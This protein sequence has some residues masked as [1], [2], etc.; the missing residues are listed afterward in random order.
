[1]TRHARPEEA[2]VTTTEDQEQSPARGAPH[3]D[4]QPLSNSQLADAL[5]L[6][7]DADSVELKLS[8]AEGYERSAVDALDI[9]PLDAEIRQVVFFDTPDLRLYHQGVVVRAR[10]VQRKPSDSVVKLRP[11]VPEQLPAKFR[12][13]EA[14]TVEVDAM[15]GGFVCSAS[16]KRAGID[17]AKVKEAFAG[18]KPVRGL[19]AEEQR[20]FFKEYAPAGVELDSL[21]RLGP[22]NVVKLKFFPA[23]LHRRL[24]AELWSYP[25]GSRILELSTK[26][27][28]AEAFQVAAECKAFLAG[29][30]IDLEG[31]QQTK[32]KAAL[33]FFAGEAAG[34]PG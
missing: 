34:A 8:V 20:K 19:F 14:L 13:A 22:I 10:R 7:R 9:D 32:T 25:D 33:R 1:L 16:M 12:K 18:R 11:V 26:C 24:V 3:Q 27:T 29:R 28:P 15:P 31:E 5:S 6:M 4:V 23:D 2:T 17:D 21:S 30:G